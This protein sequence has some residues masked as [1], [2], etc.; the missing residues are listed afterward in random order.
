MVIFG[1]Y[2]KVTTSPYA[3]DTIWVNT[4]LNRIDIGVALFGYEGFCMVY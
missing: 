1:G 4:I 3:R 2:V